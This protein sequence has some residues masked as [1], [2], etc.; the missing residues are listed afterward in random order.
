MTHTDAHAYARLILS[1]VAFQPG[2]S[3]FVKGNPAQW[4]FIASF[5]QVAYESGAKFIQV[6][7]DHALLHRARVEHSRPEHLNYVPASRAAEQQARLDEEWV[8]VSLKSPDDPNALAGIDAERNGIVNKAIATVDYPYRRQVQANRIRWI[9]ASVPTQRWG[10]HVFGMEPGPASEER[11]W[12]KLRAI[13]RLDYDDPAAEWKRLGSLLKDRRDTL[14][15][16]ALDTVHFSGPGTDLTVGLSDRSVWAGGS[17]VGQDG[18]EFF[19]N[20]PTEE[21]FTTP[22]YRRTNGRVAMTR[23]VQVLGTLVEGG[24]ME[25][26]DGRV[27]ACGATTGGEMLD[28]YFELDDHARYLGELALV[29]SESP[30]FQSG[31]VFTNTLLDEN[32]ACHIALGSSY[33]KCIRGSSELSPEQYREAGGNTSTLHT[34][35]MIGSPDVSVT[36]TTRDGRTVPIIADGEFI[37]DQ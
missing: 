6:E 26:E 10:A 8:I 28:R 25:F 35:F 13:V 32:A 14:D 24:W 9:V 31:V 20:L 18:H 29:S 12:E 11:L 37:T 34:D 4:D 7:A 3:I 21:V 36:G 33:P 2:Q 1:N 19:P 15:A 17:T 27:V 16:L 22:D 5:A 30:V 23:P